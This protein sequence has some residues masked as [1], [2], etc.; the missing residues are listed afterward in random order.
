ML[1]RKASDYNPYNVFPNSVRRIYTKISK[2]Q[3]FGGCSQKRS[4]TSNFGSY[5]SGAPEF[6][7]FRYRLVLPSQ[8]RKLRKGRFY[9]RILGHRK[10]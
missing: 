3:V 9:P 7:L 2:V 6:G 10:Q 4:K 5:G 8:N 1:S